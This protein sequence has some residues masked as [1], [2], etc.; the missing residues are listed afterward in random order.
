M[1]LLI[2]YCIALGILIRMTDSAMCYNNTIYP[3]R[4]LDSETQAHAKE[5]RLPYGYGLFSEVP[6]RHVGNC[7]IAALIYS[8]CLSG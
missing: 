5:P 6:I 4:M 8:K 1:E 2:F 7:D 3:G